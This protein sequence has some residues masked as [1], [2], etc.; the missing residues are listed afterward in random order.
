[1][2]ISA[3]IHPCLC[4]HP[5]VWVTPA[6]VTPSILT[7]ETKLALCNDFLPP[8][9]P[10]EKKSELACKCSSPGFCTV[11]W[12]WGRVGR[13]GQQI[14]S[15]I[16]SLFRTAL[17]A[18]LS[19]LI[20][21]PSQTIHMIAIFIKPPSA[22]YCSCQSLDVN[23]MGLMVQNTKFTFCWRNFCATMK[24]DTCSIGKLHFWH[25]E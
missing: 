23:W 10:H 1:M 11:D 3:R 14:Y 12:Q 2:N 21:I 24:S 22:L 25:Y 17:E 15:K 9:E 19:C 5:V 18:H 7:L 6:W 4:T 16:S 13:S 20:H 8:R